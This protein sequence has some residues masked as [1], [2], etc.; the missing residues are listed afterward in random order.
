MTSPGWIELRGLSVGS[1][2]VLA[3]IVDPNGNSSWGEWLYSYNSAFTRSVY[4]E[5][6]RY[7]LRFSNHSDGPT[8]TVH[9]SAV[10]VPPAQQLDE[11]A[12]VPRTLSQ[13]SGSDTLSLWSLKALAGDDLLLSAD[14]WQGSRQRP[15]AGPEQQRHR[16]LEPGG[17]AAACDCWSN[18]GNYLLRVQRAGLGQVA[19][20]AYSFSATWGTVSTPV[21]VTSTLSA[22]GSIAVGSTQT[23]SLEVTQA[24]LWYLDRNSVNDWQSYNYNYVQVTDPQGPRQGQRMGPADVAEPGRL[25]ADDDQ[26]VLRHQLRLR[27]EAAG[28]GRAHAAGLRA[29]CDHGLRFDLRVEDLPHRS[30]AAGDVLRYNA[31]GTTGSAPYLRFV[32]A[33]GQSLSSW[34]SSLQRCPAGQRH[35]RRPGLPDRRLHV[36]LRLGPTAASRSRSTTATPRM[37][38]R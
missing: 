18:G 30:P 34:Q 4:L 10:R 11:Q 7:A 37:C 3:Q 19:S 20:N 26:P 5:A 15:G 36:Q 29:V 22:A 21:P 14:L 32:N 27:L 9:V 24:G 33:Y 6:G 31:L 23:F 1:G 38:C 25:H 8:D 35:Q 16:Q 28:R 13:P 12:G 2:N 17:R